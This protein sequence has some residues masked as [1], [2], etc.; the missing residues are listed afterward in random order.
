VATGLAHSTNVQEGMLAPQRYNCVSKPVPLSICVRICVTMS[1]VTTQSP[2]NGQ[3]AE[4]ICGYYV[5]VE[6]GPVLI[7]AGVFSSTGALIGKT[8]FS[9]KIERG[10]AGVIP[11]IEKCIRYAVD[12]CDLGM[13]EIVA[14]GTGIPGLVCEES[15]LVTKAPQLAWQDIM[16]RQQL[17]DALAR[18]VA[19]AN[20]H[21]LGAFG[22]YAQ[23]WNSRPGTFAAIFL[24]P[25]ITG[26]LIVRGKWQNLEGRVSGEIFGAMPELNL[27]AT[28][29]RPEFEHFRSRDFRK[30]LRRGNEAVRGFALEIASKA[31][32][33]AAMLIK[34][35]A[36]EMIAIGGGMLDEMKEDLLRLVRESAAKELNAPWPEAT[37]L[38]ASG[39]GDL[40][41][42]TGAGLWAATLHA[43]QSKTTALAS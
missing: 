2:I 43:V 7:R 20:S 12:E 26:G 22:V 4:R 34:G 17:E 27:L 39:L 19:V 6:A 38:V 37:P 29:D 42:I 35:T 40:A 23:E 41:A 18:P 14:I 21:N 1:F 31:G 16:L 28:I 11:R 15:G 3:I 32:E 10:A 25:L 24:G 8:K 13:D 33:V 30:A 9:T 5:G 36:P